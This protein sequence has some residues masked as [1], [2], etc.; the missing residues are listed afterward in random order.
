MR[1]NPTTRHVLRAAV[2]VLGLVLVGGGLLLVPLPGPGWFIVILGIAVWSSE[3]EP[4]ARL[5]EFVKDKVRQW[6][7]WVRAQ[8]RWTQAGVALATFAFVAAVLWGVTKVMG[9]PGIV[10]DG[11]AAWLHAN[12]WL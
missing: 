9:V 12:L 11:V 5:L 1:N 10:P 8:S 7:Q 4:A 3:F 2:A 6:D